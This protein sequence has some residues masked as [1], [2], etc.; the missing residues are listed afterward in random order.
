MDV[1]SYRGA[2]GD[3]EHQLVNTKVREKLCTMSRESKGSKQ[4]TFEVKRLDNS[5][6]K[7]D[8]QLEISNRFEI[9]ADSK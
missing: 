9:L 3:T 1:R 7:A 5:S 4:L 8:Y 6:V 2:E